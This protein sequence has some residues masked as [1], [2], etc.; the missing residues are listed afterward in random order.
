VTLGNQLTLSFPE[1]DG[2]QIQ[3]FE[4]SMSMSVRV[5]E[6][7]PLYL[8]TPAFP[9]ELPQQLRTEIGQTF[10]DDVDLMKAL[11]MREFIDHLQDCSFRS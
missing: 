10:H 9:Q 1:I 11:A 4:P 6:E 8:H 3:M 2:R 7:E 5:P